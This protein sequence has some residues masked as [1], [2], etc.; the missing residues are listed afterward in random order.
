MMLTVDVNDDVTKPDNSSRSLLEKLPA[1][2]TR[3]IPN[4][5]SAISRASSQLPSLC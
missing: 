4:N 1:V 3:G 2:T 5:F